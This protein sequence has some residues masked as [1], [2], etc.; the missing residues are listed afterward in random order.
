MT[1]ILRHTLQRGAVL[2]RFERAV[3]NDE[4]VGSGALADLAIHV[5]Q[6]GQRVGVDVSGLHLSEH[7]V[8]TAV[9]FHLGIE[10]L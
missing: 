1:V 7:E 4:E 6:E 3:V 10:R 8:Q 2:R 5:E 9:V